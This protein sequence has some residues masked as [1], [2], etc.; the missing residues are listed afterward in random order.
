MLSSAI[1][2]SICT[3]PLFVKMHSAFIPEFCNNSLS[4]GLLTNQ[5]T[6]R[7]QHTLSET[8]ASKTNWLS[9]YCLDGIIFK[10]QMHIRHVFELKDNI[11]AFASTTQLPSYPI[12]T[13]PRKYTSKSFEVVWTEKEKYTYATREGN[14][15]CK[16]RV[17]KY[18]FSCSKGFGPL[19]WQV[20]IISFHQLHAL[21]EIHF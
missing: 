18:S 11:I 4:A 15:A 1:I 2:F 8:L 13:H 3:G 19:T 14:I 7:N 12:F 20:F 21:V 16:M 17:I 10:T 9:K 5:S 6:T